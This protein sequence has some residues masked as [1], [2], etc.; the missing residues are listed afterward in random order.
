VANLA[1]DRVPLLKLLFFWNQ[2]AKMLL[3]TDEQHLHHLN[4]NFAH[5]DIQHWNFYLPDPKLLW[6]KGDEG[7][8]YPRMAMISMILSV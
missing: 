4:G 1:N 2:H 8:E 5:H 7:D 3:D 6:R